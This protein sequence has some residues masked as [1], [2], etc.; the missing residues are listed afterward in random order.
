MSSAGPVYVA[1]K[2]PAD[3]ALDMLPNVPPLKTATVADVG[4]AVNVTGTVTAEPDTSVIPDP[5]AIEPSVTPELPPPVNTS[6][7]DAVANPGSGESRVTTF[8]SGAVTTTENRRE[9]DAG[10]FVPSVYVPIETECDAYEYVYAPMAPYVVPVATESTH[11]T[12]LL[13]IS[14]VLAVVASYP[15]SCS[16]IE[17]VFPVP[18]TTDPA[19]VP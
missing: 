17:L 18:H 19:V 5:V 1:E 9:P 13:L 15:V 8:P 10:G 6:P 16:T 7:V 2:D 14:A 4:V 12:A 11:E 3:T